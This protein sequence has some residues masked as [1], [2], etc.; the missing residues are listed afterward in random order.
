M[1]MQ[2][3]F[4]YL[5]NPISITQDMCDQ[6][7]HMNVL[8]YS[9]IFGESIEDFYAKKLGFSQEY[10]DSGF[11]SFTLED[12][13]KY[14]NE[15]LLGDIIVARYRLHR[16]N[17]KLIH[18]TAVMLNE[19]NQLCAIYETVLG[20]IDMSTRKTAEMTGSFFDNLQRIMQEHS[21]AE[22]DIPLRLEIKSL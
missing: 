1:T 20:H 14:V 21:Q 4:P 15:C 18:L 11:S 10:F 7:G 9:Q 3:T 22:I 5:S 6:N 13:I 2:R 16:V 8:Y 17:K 12:N 19:R